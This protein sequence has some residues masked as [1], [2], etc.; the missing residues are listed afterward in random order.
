MNHAALSRP[1]FPLGRVAATPGAIELL[2]RT[3]TSTFSLLRRHQC[4]DWGSVCEAD[5]K[6]NADAVLHG[7]RILSAYPLGARQEK[8]WLISE[9]DRSITTI[10]RPGEY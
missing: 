4:G 3:G 9:A 1:L 2:S 10:L 5:K 6:A 8:L 7:S